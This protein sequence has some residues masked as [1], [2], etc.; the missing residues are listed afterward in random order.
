MH[1]PD[2][3]ALA[4]ATVCASLG[5]RLLVLKPLNAVHCVTSEADGSYRIEGLLPVDIRV[6][7]SAPQHIPNHYRKATSGPLDQIVRL[8]AGGEHGGID[9]EL[10]PGGVKVDGVVL[11]ISGGEIEGAQVSSNG[12]YAWSDAEG[13]FTLWVKSGE[14]RVEANAQG[15]AENTSVGIAPGH[16]FEL[17]LTPESILIGKVV[18]AGTGTP[19]AE[20]DVFST[21]WGQ[22]W[23]GVGPDAVTREDGTF[24]IDGLEPGPYKPIAFNEETYGTA[25]TTVHL[26][27]GQTSDEVVIEVHP[28]F[29]VQGTILTGEQQTCAS[30]RVSLRDSVNKRE[31]ATRVER[32]GDVR[33]HGVL[34][35]TYDVEVSCMGF[36]SRD[37]YDAIE[38]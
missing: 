16:A 4:G 34:P 36:V 8:Q 9:I 28:A 21:D 2:G 35:G 12:A 18:A 32:E 37:D 11:D 17:L 13:A 27:L 30:G 5:S 25:G 3:Q 29:T 6:S 38:V 20:V 31:V 19:L 23:G 15:Y 24:R 22:R 14:V 33:I 10:R 26:G 7:A 1:D